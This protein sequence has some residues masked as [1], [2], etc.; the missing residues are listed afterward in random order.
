MLPLSCHPTRRQMDSSDLD[1]IIL[2][3]TWVSLQT[4]YRL[5][6]PFLHS[7]PVCP[8]HTDRQT[9]R[10]CYICRNM[11]HLLCMR[12]GLKTRWCHTSYR[13][14]SAVLIYLYYRPLSPQ[15]EIPQSQSIMWQMA[16]ATPVPQL[17]SQT[18]SMVPRPVRLF[19]SHPDEDMRLSCPGWRVTFQDGIP[20]NGYPSLH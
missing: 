2:G 15:V 19:I 3:P 20:T 7:S 18:Q 8:A 17:P 9:H 4:A 6:H 10:P 16:S 12:R 11:P 13:I 1:P 14:V 5:V